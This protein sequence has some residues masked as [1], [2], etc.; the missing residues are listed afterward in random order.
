MQDDRVAPTL[1]RGTTAQRFCPMAACG[2]PTTL[3]T[4]QVFTS[5]YPPKSKNRND[6]HRALR[7]CSS[8]MTMPLCMRSIQGRLAYSRVPRDGCP[9][10]ALVS[11]GITV[12]GDYRSTGLHPISE[13]RELRSYVDSAFN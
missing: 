11:P 2:P 9:M 6:A 5:F 12:T 7:R 13:T 8:L 10:A 3:R 4:A 1:P